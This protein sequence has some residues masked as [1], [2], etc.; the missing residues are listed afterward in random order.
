MADEPIADNSLISRNLSSISPLSQLGF[1]FGDKGAHT[2]RTIMLQELALLFQAC[3]A[4]STR[5]EYDSSILDLNCLGKHTVSSRKLTVQRMHE[6]YALQNDVALFRVFRYFWDLDEK[7]RPLLALFTA[8]AR[9]PILRISADTV[10]ALPIGQ[11][12]NRQNAYNVLADALQKRMNEATIDKVLRN[13]SASWTL[14]G[15]LEGRVR[16]IRRPVTPTIIS[17]TFAL[18]L[19]YMLGYRSASLLT[20]LWAKLLDTSSANL[21]EIAVDA[22]K[23]GLLEMS[24]SGGMVTISFNSLLTE[25]ER[26]LVHGTH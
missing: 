26:R 8:L 17:A 14:S 22:K 5:D 4:D 20:T 15:H 9:D 16:K 24:Q 18:L 1:R 7:S 2:S 12:L 3:P 21:M 13:T 10:L 6:M 11:E 23:M 19:G 25:N